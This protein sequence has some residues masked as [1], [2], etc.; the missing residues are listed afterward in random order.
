MS[1]ISESIKIESILVAAARALEKWKQEWLLPPCGVL[2]VMKRF[3][4]RERWCLHSSECMK[5][6]WALPFKM[7]HCVL[8]EFHIPVNT[9]E[10]VKESVVEGREEEW[11][12]EGGRWYDYA[13]HEFSQFKGKCDPASLK[14]NRVLVWSQRPQISSKGWS[15]H[16]FLQLG[17]A[18]GTV[19]HKMLRS[20]WSLFQ[21]RGFCSDSEP[22]KYLP[23]LGSGPPPWGS[24][25]TWGTQDSVSP[26]GLQSY[27]ATGRDPFVSALNWVR[28]AFPSA[29]QGKDLD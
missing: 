16:R 5:C 13:W 24:V 17:A 6:H 23:A 29:W 12:R 2:G 11:E 3:E 4:N 26:S 19:S 15:C 18:F 7:V 8:C 27:Q 28:P 22:H 14:Q 20:V 21:H 9:E 10:R 25:G 1:R